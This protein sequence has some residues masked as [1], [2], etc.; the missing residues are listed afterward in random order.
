MLNNVLFAS[1]TDARRRWTT[2]VPGFEVPGFGGALRCA[3]AGVSG[4]VAGFGAAAAGF[5]VKAGLAACT[6][7]RTAGIDDPPINISESGVKCLR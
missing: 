1:L 6:G 3:G 5:G 2:S 7:G 4:L